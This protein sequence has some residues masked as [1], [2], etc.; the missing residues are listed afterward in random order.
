VSLYKEYLKER[1]DKDIVESEKGF[2]TFKTFENGECYLQDIYVVPSER[3]NGVA[4]EMANKVV[5]IAK[6]RQCTLLVGSV[7][8][9]DQN[10]TRNMKV[11]LAYGMEIYKNVGTMIFLKKKIGVE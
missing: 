6:E 11:F 10:A 2:A 5:E 7:C 8:T 1:E 3:K 4:T 9:E